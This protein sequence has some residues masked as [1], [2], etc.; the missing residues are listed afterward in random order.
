M[1][2][3]VFHRPLDSLPSS[4]SITCSVHVSK[5]RICICKSHATI[6][7]TRTTVVRYS[8]V[9]FARSSLVGLMVTKQLFGISADPAMIQPQR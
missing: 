2:K 5:S 6:H 7:E 1:I 9:L 4:E 8:R 3:R